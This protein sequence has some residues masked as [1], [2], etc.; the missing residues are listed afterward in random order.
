MLE[1]LNVMN[2]ADSRVKSDNATVL[3]VR[4]PTVII[5]RIRFGLLIE[6]LS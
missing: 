6:P 2:A 4:R 1:R 3:F 5:E